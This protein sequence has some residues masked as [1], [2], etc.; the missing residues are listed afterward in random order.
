[1]RIIYDSFIYFRD[2]L[3]RMSFTLKTREKSVW[4]ASMSMMETCQ[5]KG[6]SELDCR[7]HIMVLQNYGNQLYACGTYAFSP[8]C[9]WRQ[10]SGSFEKLI[11]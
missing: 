4:E 9:S 5:N 3:Y 2:T 11:I 8:Y 7:N 1:M 10:V 6:Q